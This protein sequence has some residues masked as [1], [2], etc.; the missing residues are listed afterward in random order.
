MAKKK[1]KS[2]S[3]SV[4]PKKGGST[5]SKIEDTSI[6]DK[7]TEFFLC[8]ACDAEAEDESI[9]CHDCKQWAHYKCSQLT[10]LQ[11]SF[12]TDSPD[13]IQ[14]VCPTCVKG[15]GEK[16]GTFEAKIDRLQEMI[17][18]LTAKIG[19]LESGCNGASLDEKIEKIVDKKLAEKI[20]EKGEKEDRKNNLIIVNLM[21]SKKETAEERKKEDLENLR[22]LVREKNPDLEGETL[23]EPTRLGKI[24]GTRPRLLR[25]K[26]KSAEVKTEFLKLRLNAEGVPV[27]KRVYIN[28][29]YTP[30]ER[31]MNKKLREELKTRIKNGE[32]DIG[33]RGGKIVSVKWQARPGQV[34]HENN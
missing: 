26:V 30:A 16:K 25:V 22:K 4:T 19:R 24:G 31:E 21:E 10:N 27:E 28:P 33:I 34:S 17:A 13:A 2:K 15:E 32:K 9:Q 3:D 6:A 1:G 11:L 20:E 18:V 7:S 29:D 8:L 23:E 12:L 5:S 14:W